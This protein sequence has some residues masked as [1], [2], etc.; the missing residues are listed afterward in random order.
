MIIN[1]RSFMLLASTAL[2]IRPALAAETAE[3]IYSGGPILTMDDANP[4]A[5]AVAVK[6]GRIVAAG[7]AAEVMKLKSAD[8]RLI[9]LAGKTMVPG[10]V[11]AHGHIV[12]GGL[13]ALSA[14]LLPPPDGPGTDI[15]AIQNILREWWEANKETVE[16]VNLIIGF[17]YD[18]SQLKELRHPDRNDL[19]AVSKDIPVV[20]VHQSGHL[21][22]LNSKALELINYTADTPDPVGGVIQRQPG[23]KEPNGVLEETALMAA[24]PKILKD[25]GPEGLKAFAEA[26]AE[27]WSSF[28]YTTVQEG[29]AIPSLCK[30]MQAVAAEGKFKVD[31][32]AYPDALVDRDYIKEN[33]GTT[34]KNRYRLGGAKLSIDGSPQGFTAWRDR[35][36]YAPVGNY[37][38]GYVGYSAA[39]PEKFIETMEWAFANNIQTITHANGEAASDLLIAAIANA[40]AKHGKADRRHVL[41]HGQ[42]ER[43]DQVDSFVRLGVIPSLFPM[44][45]YYW[46]DWHR[47]HTV[48][49]ELAD[50]IS[51]TGWY[52]KRGSIFTSHHDAPVAFPNSMRILDATVTRRSRSGDIIGPA[53]RVSVDEGLKALTIWAAYQHFEESDK[54]SIEKGKLAD[55]VILSDD[56]TAVD[57]ETLDQL[58]I[59]ETIKEGQTIYVRGQ[60]KADLIRKGNK[61]LMNTAMHEMFKQI[62]V[63]FEVEWLPQSYQTDDVR[64][65]VATNYEGCAVTLMLPRLFG[66]P[67]EGAEVAS[68][69]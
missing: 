52:L 29:R 35:P 1:R 27:L 64:A 42:F 9:D 23:S 48:G 16:A 69:E 41:I 6:G 38:P 59:V 5:E 40:T 4:R 2:A 34:Y 12:M 14:N 65:Q 13:Q 20:I 39:P 10:F 36:Y 56:P 53:Q 15:A 67:M 32:V 45:T 31:V 24:V 37:P 3:I 49:P 33:V 18:Q 63:Q 7:P 47:E 19:D 61:D 60:K 46:G 22:S 11:D 66:L 44:H 54:G 51:P 57:P 43:E 28:G 8:T 55:L 58:E 30:V 50:N 21:G 17:G 25:V 26:G 62:Y 68:G